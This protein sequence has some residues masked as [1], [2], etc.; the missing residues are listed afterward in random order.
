MKLKLCKCGELPD[1]KQTLYTLQIVCGNC[2]E[3]GKVFYGDYYDEGFMLTSYG[4]EA[5]EEWNRRVSE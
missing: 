4:K 5:V 1:F 2:G 3:C